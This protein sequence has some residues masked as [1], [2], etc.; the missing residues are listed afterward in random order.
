MMSNEAL[1]SFHR[2]SQAQAERESEKASA[3]ER[4]REREREGLWGNIVHSPLT[5]IASPFV[6]GGTDPGLYERE[7]EREREKGS[8]RKYTAAAEGWGT[9]TSLSE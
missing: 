8:N 1:Q 3:T 9:A 5:G 2:R 4:E 7:R 6:C